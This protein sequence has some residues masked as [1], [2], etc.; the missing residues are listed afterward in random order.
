MEQEKHS[1]RDFFSVIFKHKT[2]IS[3]IFLAVV[4]IVIVIT[5]LIPPTYQAKSVVL[6]KLGREYVYRSEIGNEGPT[7]AFSPA[8]Q[9]ELVNTEIK[10][11][12]NPDLIRRVLNAFGVKRLYPEV[13]ESQIEGVPPIEKAILKFQEALSVSGVKKSNI[14]ELSYEHREPELAAKAV[15]LL[16]ELYKEKHLQ[17]YS[18]PQ[19]SFLQSQLGSYR[20]RLNASENSLQSFKQQHGIYSLDEQ[21]NLLL[22]QR[23]ELDAALKENQN[24]IQELKQRLASTKR[25]IGSMLEKAPLYTASDR[26]EIITS[27]KGR[28]FEAQIKEQDLLTKYNENS[29]LVQNVRKEIQMAK[30]FLAEQEK[31]ISSKVRT[32][33]VIYQEIERDKM[34]AETELVAQEARYN[35]LK[36]QIEQ[37]GAELRGLDLREKGFQDLKRQVLAN[38]RHY[39][40]YLDKFEE[41]RISEDMNK[42]KIAN[43][44]VVQTAATPSEPISPRKGL[45]GI[46]AIVFGAASGLGA[47]F[48]SEHTAQGMS[49]PESA[50]K[51]LQLPVLATIP[52]R[53]T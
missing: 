18:D 10:I 7:M 27:T 28:L 14:I 21:R 41:A 3:I 6:V 49:T 33:N 20:Q 4:T 51:H 25:Q 30:D 40:N 36:R 34:K 12:T 9:E 45:N 47:A 23:G 8:N 39:Q 32:G 31:D 42:K 53:K 16:V 44:S 52:M 29:R 38:E 43:I 37:T 35:I 24:R 46:L 26:D 13:F 5:F 1:T 11:M 19:S 17:V 50:E 2:R 15:N 22:N 48:F